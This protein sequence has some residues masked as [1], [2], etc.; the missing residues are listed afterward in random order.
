[1]SLSC[2]CLQ[3]RHV[4][5][6]PRLG[7]RS[8]RYDVRVS[9]NAAIS[10]I[11]E[12]PSQPAMSAAMRRPTDIRVEICAINR[13]T[14]IPPPIEHGGCKQSHYHNTFRNTAIGRVTRCCET[15]FV[16]LLRLPPALGCDL[17][18]RRFGRHSEGFGLISGNGCIER[19]FQRGGIFD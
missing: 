18:T 14:Q 5:S 12:A 10:P 13:P 16:L 6:E 19:T 3:S 2:E 17:M 15:F 7:P 1:M 8:S 4:R 9:I 11:S